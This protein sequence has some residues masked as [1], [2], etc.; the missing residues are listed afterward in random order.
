MGKW[1]VGGDYGD[2]VSIGYKS[3]CAAAPEIY[4]WTKRCRVD[5]GKYCS[6]AGGCKLITGA[7]H[8]TDW[9]STY[10]FFGCKRGHP[11][12]KG[13]ILI[14]NDVWIGHSATIGSGVT[15]GDGAV[16]AT[17]SLVVKDVPPYAIVGGNPAK[18]I[19]FRFDEETISKLLKIKWW[20]WDKNEVKK[21]AG[22]LCSDN[23][24]EFFKKFEN[25]LR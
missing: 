3:Y 13:N 19:K 11:A 7:E 18:I 4:M 22:L 16:I 8:R 24:N 17:E 12:T 5:I 6:I 9:I 2:R 1:Y 14:G 23:L 15:V 20:E 25:E 21:N 10:P